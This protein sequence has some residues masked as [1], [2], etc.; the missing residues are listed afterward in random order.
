MS[1]LRVAYDMQVL[2]TPHNTMYVVHVRYMHATCTHTN[3]VK[4]KLLHVYILEKYA[5]FVT[6]DRF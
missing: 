5:K 6:N 4:G 3:R 1:T 2:E